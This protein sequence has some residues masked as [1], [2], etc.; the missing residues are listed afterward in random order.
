MV[1]NTPTNVTGLRIG[2]VEGWAMS[3][4]C[5]QRQIGFE[6]NDPNKYT[7]VHFESQHDMMRGLLSGQ[8]DA[9]L[10]VDVFDT[11]KLGIVSAGPS[12]KCTQ[13]GASVMTMYGSPLV[14]WWNEAFATMRADGS[15][16]QLCNRSS[17]THAAKG[18]IVCL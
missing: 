15:F 8:V 13:G 2:F 3:R 16:R 1:S 10:M 5:F 4:R 14:D 17:H 18:R 9:V 6:G 11:N 7:A 12:F